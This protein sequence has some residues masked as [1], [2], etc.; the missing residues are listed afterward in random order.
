MSPFPFPAGGLPVHSVCRP[1]ATCV[2]HGHGQSLGTP[3][4]GGTSPTSGGSGSNNL[5][6]MV[7]VEVRGI[8]VVGVEVVMVYR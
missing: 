2:F 4:R 1:K 5:N 6:G 3:A 8:V 7:V